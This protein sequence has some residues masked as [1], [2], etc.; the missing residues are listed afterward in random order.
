MNRIPETDPVE[1]LMEAICEI[2]WKPYVCADEDEL[3]R[4]CDVCEMEKE[5]KTYAAKIRGEKLDK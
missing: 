5:V 1:E 3:E 2:C 4:H